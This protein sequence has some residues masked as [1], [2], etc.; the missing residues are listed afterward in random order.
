MYLPFRTVATVTV[1]LGAPAA[2]RAQMIPWSQYGSVTQHLG[3]TE[4]VIRYRRPVARGRELFG[5]LVK[6]DAP[7]TP[8]ADSATTIRFSTPVTM[9]QD[10]VPAGLYSIWMVP[11]PEAWQVILSTAWD[12][13]HTPYPEGHDALRLT[14][15]PTRG[16]H[17]E[18]L[19]FHF[20]LVDGP[21]AVLAFQW[22]ETMLEIP[23][24]ITVV[25]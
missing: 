1:L 4:I 15:I 23:I 12:V 18:T 21:R 8:G 17:T 5:A 24:A 7:W 6:W 10:T 3:E 16:P 13:Y 20:P 25:E 22:G 9:G 19:S 14:V 11:N 2:L